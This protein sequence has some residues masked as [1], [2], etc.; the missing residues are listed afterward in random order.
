MPWS[1]GMR[2]SGVRMTMLKKPWMVFFNSLLVNQQVLLRY[3]RV[4]AAHPVS[5]V[6][7]EVVEAD[8]NNDQ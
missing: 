4:A 8:Q 3:G 1:A 6:E 5:G 7:I 2:A